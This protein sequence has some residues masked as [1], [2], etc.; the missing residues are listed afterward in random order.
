MTT[1]DTT[2][3]SGE[4]TPDT[5]GSHAESDEPPAGTP[6]E[7]L[8]SIEDLS[9]RFPSQRGPIEAI[10]EID[11]EIGAGETVGLVGESGSGK[12]VTARSILQL[13]ESSASLDGTVRFDGQ[14]LIDMDEEDLRS[15]RGNRISMIFQDAGAALNPVLT[16]GDQVSETI[17]MHQDIPGESISRLERNA[18]TSLL[19]PKD[20]PK[21]FEESWERTVELFDRVG[22]PEPDRR[23]LEYPHEYSGGMRQ[24][25][26]IAM[27]LSCQPELLIADEP[28]TALDVTIEAQI[29]DLIEELQAEFGSSVLFITHDMGVINEVADRVAVMYAGRVV[30]TGPTRELF[31][32]PKHPYTE[33][34]LESV[35]TLDGTE[36]LDPLPGNVPDPQKRPSGCPFRTRC[37]SANAAC[38]SRFPPV[39]P[40]GPD[41]DPAAVSEQGSTEIPPPRRAESSDH[42]TRCVL[43]GDADALQTADQPE[44]PS[45]ERGESR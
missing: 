27:A 6:S 13:F 2:A 34:L 4:S 8:L 23:A 44:S 28:T 45:D 16:V 24:R 32:N 18:F 38:D 10:S 25:A 36:S 7:P 39:Y 5:D 31:E 41:D 17:R 3:E 37:P 22:I 11:I 40:V 20:W 15:I 29:L 26:M 21:R 30:E 33:A 43:Y 42:T 35:P 19:R 12:S 9:V 14:N 1:H